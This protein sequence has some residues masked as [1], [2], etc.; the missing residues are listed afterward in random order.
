MYSF[1]LLVPFSAFVEI[2]KFPCVVSGNIYI[3]NFVN[4]FTVH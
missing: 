4:V 2:W 1:L 3:W